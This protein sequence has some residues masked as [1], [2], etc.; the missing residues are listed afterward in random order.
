MV[1]FGWRTCLA[2]KRTYI[3]LQSIYELQKLPWNGFTIFDTNHTSAGFSE[4]IVRAEISNEDTVVTCETTRSHAELTRFKKIVMAF[5]DLSSIH[6]WPFQLLLSPCDTCLS[7]IAI[8]FHLAPEKE[9]TRYGNLRTTVSKLLCYRT[10]AH[11]CC[12]CDSRLLIE[13]SFFFSHVRKK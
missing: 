9:N 1:A 10:R 6:S 4:Y 5:S 7:S 8:F 12:A 3:F 2:E 13:N 11:I